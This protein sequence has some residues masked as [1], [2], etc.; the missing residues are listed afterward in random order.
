MVAGDGLPLVWVWSYN[1]VFGGLVWCFNGVLEMVVVV[2]FGVFGWLSLVFGGA[3]V[4]LGV[5]CFKRDNN[6]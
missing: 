5:W 1:G 3:G 6:F 2:V 4:F